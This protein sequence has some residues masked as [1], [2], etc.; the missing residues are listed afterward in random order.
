MPQKARILLVDD[1]AENLIALE[2]IL[3]SLNQE[4]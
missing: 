1:R 4:L 3:S 2:A